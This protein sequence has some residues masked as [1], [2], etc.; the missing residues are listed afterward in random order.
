MTVNQTRRFSGVLAC[1]LLAALLTMAA[2]AEEVVQTAYD[3]QIACFS[4]SG[5]DDGALDGIVLTAVPDDGRTALCLGSRILRAG[6]VLTGDMLAS[7]VLTPDESGADGTVEYLPVSSGMVGEPAAMTF[8]IGSRKN[9]PPTARDGSLETYRNIAVT[10]SLEGSDPDGD[11]LTFALVQAPRRGSVEL[12]ADGSFTYTP[13]NNK[14]GKDS[15]CYTASDP[16]GLT[17]DPATVTIQILRPADKTTYADM[18]GDPDEFA[19]LWLREQGVFYGE[20]ISSVTVFGPETPVTRGE[21][22]VMMMDTFDLTPTDETLST[23]FADEAETPVWMQP[24]VAAALRSGLIT[25]VRSGA[26]MV[27][28]PEAQL[29]RAEAAVLVNGILGLE[30]DEAQTVFAPEQEAVPAWA[31]EDLSALCTAALMQPGD[32]A[33]AVTRREAARLLY[34]ASRFVS[35]DAYSGTLLAWAME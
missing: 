14:V 27:Y 32:P 11:A 31:A 28:R 30:G 3:E 23:G 6:D 29:T 15:F 1:L 24:Y 17:S 16:D 4:G 20:Q 2:S 26:G 8:S 10:G 34:A 35:S 33:A 18:A 7:V 13:E 22:L 9:Q 25:G 19:A 21:F 5:F 12:A